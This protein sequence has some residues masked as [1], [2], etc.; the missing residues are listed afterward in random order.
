MLNRLFQHSARTFSL[1]EGRLCFHGPESA[2]DQPMLDAAK[3]KVSKAWSWTKDRAGEFRGWSVEK[4]TNA[5][6]V[7]GPWTDAALLNMPKHVQSL[8]RYISSNPSVAEETKMQ[9]LSNLQEFML[10][11][12]APVVDIVALA[13][14]N[15]AP[16]KLATDHLEALTNHVEWIRAFK[17]PDFLADQ[18]SQE[19]YQSSEKQKHTPEFLLK[20]LDKSE[21]LELYKLY[22]DSFIH[23]DVQ[24]EH[25]TV[26]GDDVANDKKRMGSLVA[27]RETIAS[28]MQTMITGD[29]PQND[30]DKSIQDIAFES[31]E[32]RYKNDPSLVQREAEKA[33]RD[34][35]ALTLFNGAKKLGVFPPDVLDVINTKLA[36][37][38]EDRERMIV[39][40]QDRRSAMEAKVRVKEASNILDRME[41]WE[42][43]ALIAVIGY[44]AVRHTKLAVTGLLVYLGFKYIGNVQDPL[45]A[46]ARK[47]K[48][49]ADYLSGKNQK[50]RNALG[51]DHEKTPEEMAESMV[52]FAEG[53]DLHNIEEEAEVLMTLSGK[54]L[55]ELSNAFSVTKT[56][57]NLDLKLLYG[58][59]KNIPP[60]LKSEDHCRAMTRAVGYIFFALYRSNHPGDPEVKAV[61][62][63]MARLDDNTTWMDELKKPGNEQLARSYENLV[64]RGKL[65]G[66]KDARQL[67]T[68]IETQVTT[69]I[70]PKQ[71]PT[72]AQ[73]VLGPKGLSGQM[74]VVLN[75]KVQMPNQVVV[76][77]P[78]I[79]GG[80]D[81]SAVVVAPGMVFPAGTKLP[82]GTVLP[83][84]A[85][86][87]DV[88][89][90]P[91]AIDPKAVIMDPTFVAPP[92]LVLPPGAVIPKDT[93]IPPSHVLPPGTVLK[94]VQ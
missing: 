12:P 15:M 87:P 89:L 39:G 86:T 21:R 78:R 49:G 62:D 19:F 5:K 83:P 94:P 30:P 51:W 3:E 68:F 1:A 16:D 50:A 4:Y 25:H 70:A 71:A 34:P 52:R 92:G 2:P 91:P 90:P 42:K 48:E 56:G 41:T 38:K 20:T 73:V 9:M 23:K 11:A 79:A 81:T 65:D 27:N 44:A 32:K 77:A 26:F 45:G 69:Y 36:H 57:W 10:S 80:V 6:S 75:G 63:R 61:S 8:W 55:A 13:V 29:I 43:L 82:P 22:V 14:S 76:P 88:V 18:I 40:V 59:Q 33:L 7:I 60:Y 31:L 67:H 93:V 24:A 58:S 53:E 28:A 54:T 35:S 72:P 85:V 74:G 37:R 47:L 66:Y 46:G 84:F 64:V 17:S